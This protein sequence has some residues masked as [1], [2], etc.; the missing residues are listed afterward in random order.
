MIR[1]HALCIAAALVFAVQFSEVKVI[2]LWVQKS[3]GVAG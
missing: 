1:A 2:S 3:C